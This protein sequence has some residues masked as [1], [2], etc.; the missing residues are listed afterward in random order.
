MIKKTNISLEFF[1]FFGVLVIVLYNFPN[2]NPLFNNFL[3]EH[4]H[5]FTIFFFVHSSFFF[6]N[7]LEER[8]SNFQFLKST[9]IRKFIKIYPIHFFMLLIFALI[10]CLKNSYIQEF[11]YTS[12]Y[13]AYTL[14]DFVVNLFFLNA[15][16]FS[17][18]SFNQ[19]SW[20]VSLIFWQLIIFS[21]LF[22]LNKKLFQYSLLAI[23]F[24]TFII[25]VTNFNYEFLHKFKVILFTYAF[26][27]T[28]AIIYI[29]KNYLP[30]HLNIYYLSFG[31]LLLIFGLMTQF[32]ILVL[33]LLYYCIIYYLI[34]IRDVFEMIIPKYLKSIVL[35]LGYVSFYWYM[36]HF[37]FTFIFRQ[38]AKIYFEINTDELNRL[39]FDNDYSMLITMSML[40]LS[41]LFAQLIMKVNYIF[42]RFK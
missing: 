7:S 33:P 12:S 10:E 34:N 29:Q 37:L 5:Y 9:S 17:P 8:K 26:V 13:E 41:F 36:S 2:D 6:T 1:K 11:N 16:E 21:I 3:V 23:F 14:F 19:P 40:I 31:I 18:R 28:S 30:T 15:F 32:I 20:A 39:I 27:F 22:S 24:S 35:N 42:N 4:V 25:L 38:I